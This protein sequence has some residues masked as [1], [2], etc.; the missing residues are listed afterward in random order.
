MQK[1]RRNTE[2]I[3]DEESTIADNIEFTV[4][5]YIQVRYVPWKKQQMKT[6][7]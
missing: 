3:V 2:C 1:K 7:S 5:D 6:Y 4:V